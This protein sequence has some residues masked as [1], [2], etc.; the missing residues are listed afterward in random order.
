MNQGLIP[1]RQILYKDYIPSLPWQAFWFGCLLLIFSNSSGYTK[2][3]FSVIYRIFLHPS[4]SDLV[5]N[6]CT[7]S[8]LIWRV[9]ICLLLLLLLPLWLSLSESPYLCLHLQ[10]HVLLFSLATS[11]LKEFFCVVKT[12]PEMYCFFSGSAE[13]QSL[14]NFSKLYTTTSTASCQP[15]ELL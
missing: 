10:E 1:A 9:S 8:C 5:V 15:S 7:E 4:S 2:N 11:I 13:S 3:G 6:S 14:V 12:N